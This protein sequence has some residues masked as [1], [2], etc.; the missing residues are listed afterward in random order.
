MEKEFWNHLDCQEYCRDN[1]LAYFKRDLSI[2]CNKKCI[3]STYESIFNKIQNGSNNY[4]ESWRSDQFMKLYIDYDKKENKETHLDDT[5]DLSHK[6]DLYNI[7]SEIRKIIPEITDVSILKTIPDVTKKS[8]HII[9]DGI[10]FENYN[11]IRDFM[12]DKIKPRFTELF[13]KKII[14]TKV[15]GNLCFRSLL[16]TKFGQDRKLMLLKTEPFMTE[17]REDFVTDIT[18]DLFKKTCLTFVPDYCIKH[19][20]IKREQTH[21]EEQQN[22]NGDIYTDKEVLKKY[23]DILDADRYT[24]YNK[25]IKIGFI[26]YSISI[27]NK[28]L[29]HYFSAKWEG[30]S[31]DATEQKWMSFNSSSDYIYTIHSLMYIAR[32][33]NITDYNEITKDIPDNDIRF[34]E[35][36]DNVLSNFV[37]R[38]YG[39]TFVCSNPEKK[40]WYYFNGI[41][42]VLDNKNSKLRTLLFTEVYNKIENYRKELIEQKVHENIIKKYKAISSKLG[43]GK[44]LNCIEYVFYNPDFY[45]IINQN[46]H[47][48]GFDNG[49]YD[50]KTFQFRKSVPTDYITLT[51][52]YNYQFFDNESELYKKI[53]TI[54]SQIL[55]KQDVRE[56]TLKSLSSCLDG[57]TRYE[58][59]YIWSG[60]HNSGANGK[61]TIMTLMEYALGDYA[62]TVAPTLFTTKR[63]SANNANSALVSIFG[64]RLVIT[65]EPEANEKIQVS[66][67]KS[68]TGGDTI[69]TR[70][71]NS[72]QMT[73]KPTSKFFMLCNIIPSLSSIDGG[74]I[75]RLKITEY[76]S[77]FVDD[78]REK[79]PNNPN[80]LYEFKLDH[81]L[82]TNL[83]KFKECFMC[84]LIEYYKLYDSTGLD[85]PED[86]I[87]VTRKYEDDN[88]H[89]KTYVD[90]NLV[91]TE[92]R[93]EFVSKNDLKDAFKLDKNMLYTFKKFSTF[94]SS[95]L[96]I[97]SVDFEKD[98][99]GNERLPGYKFKKGE[100]E[101]CIDSD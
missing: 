89:I 15:Y 86:V 65:S 62:V 53:S 44:E 91:K 77:K 51:T 8:Y 52:G 13:D 63:E 20:Y 64:K 36:T 38:L 35:I 69:S 74:T 83:P 82:K 76:V 46:K 80:E 22:D 85:P 43:S 57:E 5:S 58:Y 9:F 25:W 10:Y 61:T 30:Y 81:S 3:A 55:P 59:F 98:T 48:V 7:I 19:S 67:M 28:D 87:K 29:W 11:V 4:Y 26:L 60:K 40:E 54:I 73:F 21:E 1:N 18:V 32:I 75:R 27:D 94:S 96:Q 95:L 79:D 92:I 71:L 33:D 39:D 42:W 90:E 23:L 66:T 47:L 100:Q 6:N 14:D 2:R 50:L 56:F 49:V 12:M 101:T 68:L 84:L 37:Y 45:K 17:L 41:R 31:K 93:E 70:E 88:N 78:P 16:C 97:L 34:L 24:D 99:K 72:R